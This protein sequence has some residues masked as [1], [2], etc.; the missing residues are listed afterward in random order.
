LDNINFQLLMSGKICYDEVD[1]IKRI[2]RTQSIALPFIMRNMAEYRKQLRRMAVTN[3]LHLPHPTYLPSK[4]YLQRLQEREAGILHRRK[5]RKRKKKRSSTSS[6]ASESSSSSSCY[7]LEEQSDE[8]KEAVQDPDSSSQNSQSIFSVQSNSLP[9]PMTLPVSKLPRPHGQLNAHSNSLLIRHSSLSPCAEAMGAGDEES[10][11]EQPPATSS[12]MPSNVSMFSIF[13]E[14][15][16]SASVSGEDKSFLCSFPESCHMFTEGSAQSCS[17]LKQAVKESTQLVKLEE[18]PLTSRLP[19][20]APRQCSR[21]IVRNCGGKLVI[22]TTPQQQAMDEMRHDCGEQCE[23][24]LHRRPHTAS[25]ARSWL[26]TAADSK[27]HRLRTEY[28]DET[29]TSVAP[30]A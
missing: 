2:A 11:K 4:Q 25:P 15:K 24:L 17:D 20:W 1:R 28:S 6:T 19:G 16:D 3:G 8:F 30:Q 26:V 7:K 12:D 29:A 18:R 5:V 22:A 9:Q 23:A 10:S 13:P 14:P 21:Y 27:S